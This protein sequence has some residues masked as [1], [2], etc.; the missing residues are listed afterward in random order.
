MNLSVVIQSIINGLLSGG[1]YALVAVGVTIIFGV[2]KIV[3]FAAGAYLVWGMYF[4][5]LWQKNIAVSPYALIPFVIVSMI[6]FCYVTFKSTIRQV[7][8]KGGSSLILITVGLSFFLQ[9]LAETV[10]GTNP[11][12]VDSNIKLASFNIG[13]F[14]IGYP[15]LIAF[16]AMLILIILVNMLLNKTSIGRAMRSTAEKPEVAKLLGVHTEMIYT[17]SFVL[18]VT[19]A[20]LSGVLITPLYYVTAT[21]GNTFRIAPLMAVVLGGMGS[22]KGSLVGGMLVGIVEQLVATLISA[23]LGTAGICILF[24]IVLYLKPYGLFGK[25]VRAA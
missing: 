4:T 5:W 20:G 14:T 8:D 15:R 7:I 6:F 18:G 13:E 22:I 1:V 3:N 16:G 10:F 12:T 24:L 25:E 21:A 9:N 19:L 11:Q 17:F 2:M 23:D